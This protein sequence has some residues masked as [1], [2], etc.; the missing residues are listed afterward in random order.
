MLTARSMKGFLNQPYP[1]L[2]VDAYILCRNQSHKLY[3]L[4]D[5]FLS[6]LFEPPNTTSYLI[7][8]EKKLPESNLNSQHEAYLTLS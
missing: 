3:L 6:S 5:G 7:S 2:D 8:A 1:H 4:P